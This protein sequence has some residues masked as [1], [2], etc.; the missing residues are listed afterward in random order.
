MEIQSMQEV[1]GSTSLPQIQNQLIN[2]ALVE[3]NKAKD[4]IIITTED[5]SFAG[6]IYKEIKGWI[7]RLDDEEKKITKPLLE[8]I[9]AARAL[10]RGPKQKANDVKNILN[11]RMVR[12]A[13]DQERIRREAERKLQEEAKR[14]A[15][16]EALAQALEAEAAGE[17]EEA[18]QILS[19]P[20][21]V[22][23]VKVMSEV[24][25]SKKTQIRQTWS[26]EIIDVMALVKGIAEGKVD[27]QAIEPNNLIKNHSFL[28]TMATRY[29][30]ALNIPG[31]RSISK[32][33]QI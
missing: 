28:N 19:E 15:E 12:W 21:Y 2:Q 5:Y 24:P 29:K 4:I 10:F 23:Q 1:E 33:T 18:E 7:K 13:E 8:G 20:V 6:L 17:K 9:E 3:V 26:C 30:E 14:R 32:R 31:V 25:R 16:E 27:I 11:T 22:P